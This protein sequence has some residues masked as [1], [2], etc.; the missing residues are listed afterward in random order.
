MAAVRSSN[1]DLFE[2]TPQLTLP[3]PPPEFS[4]EQNLRGNTFKSELKVDSLSER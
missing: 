2:A 4:P 3:D 1:R